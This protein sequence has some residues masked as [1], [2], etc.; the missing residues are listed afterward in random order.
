MKLQFYL[1]FRTQF[2]QSLWISGDTEELGMDDPVRAKS[3]DYLNEEFWHTSFEIKK[4][5]LQKNIRYKYLLKD[6]EG[7]LI[8][9][10]GNDRIISSKSLFGDAHH[11]D[12]NE[13]QFIDTWNH[14]G[15][16][17]NAFFTAP[18][19]NV[20]LKTNKPKFKS[21]PDKNFTHTFKVKAPIL[22]K[23]DV[24]CISGS[25]EVLG[26]WSTSK[27][28][29]LAKEDDWW[30]INIDLSESEFPLTYKYG[31]FDAKENKFVAFESGNN[32]IIY[33]DISKKMIAVLHDGFIHF[34]NN[35]WKGAGVAIPV[36]SLR[37]KN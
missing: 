9:E 25:G 5:D 1:R 7:E 29:L 10:W 4:K 28:I 3:M 13:V 6:K 19:K 37:S 20:L 36:F 14:A 16:Y 34:P 11:N 8:F 26:N 21:K 27:P 18:F 32:R 30:T 31:V 22:K 12:L 17:E 24:V 33:N 2:G 15:E 35:S 23:N